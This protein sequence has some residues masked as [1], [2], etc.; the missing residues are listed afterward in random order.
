MIDY[1]ELSKWKQD[2]VDK[3]V[4]EEIEP[5]HRINKSNG[6]EWDEPDH[7]L[8]QIHAGNYCA[9]CWNVYYNCLCSH[10]S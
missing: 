6:F 9:V 1:R 7:T 3:S 8:N 2:K 4:V 5:G 10:S